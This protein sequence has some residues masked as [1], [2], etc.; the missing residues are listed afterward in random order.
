ML[1]NGRY[2]MNHNDSENIFE[3]HVREEC[4]SDG[5]VEL[6]V[7]LFVYLNAV[8]FSECFPNCLI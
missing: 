5:S 7:A 4:G 6:E 1:E 8:E 2:F 3:H